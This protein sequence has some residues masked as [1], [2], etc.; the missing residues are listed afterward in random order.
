MKIDILNLKDGTT[1]YFERLSEL[2]LDISAFDFHLDGPVDSHIVVNKTGNKVKVTIIADFTVKM[3]C[4][5]CLEE[6]TTRFHTEDTYF[7]QPGKE[8]EENEEKYLNDEDVFTIFAPTQEID[9]L[10]LVRD[11]V[12]L[13]V[14]MKPLCKE[15]CKGLCPVCG[16][17]L[18]LE[19]CPHS[20]NNS[21]YLPKDD[22]KS[23]LNELKKK[24][25]ND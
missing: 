13:S 4:S 24:L 7:V 20:Q 23:K 10:P 16:V 6:F 25:E 17:N 1:E 21:D 19:K 8:P 9:T 3:T 5:R 2:E 22:W 14:P 12:I 18:N 15:D 11:S